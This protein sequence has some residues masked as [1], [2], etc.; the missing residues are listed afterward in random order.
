NGYHLV[1]VRSRGK[2]PVSPSWQHGEA[3][4]SLLRVTDDAANTGMLCSGL[5]VVD[6]D[7]DDPKLV[8]EIT[9]AVHDLLPRGAIIRRRAG[10]PRYAMVFRAE[11]EPGKLSV[12]SATGKVE[13]LGSGQQLVIDGVHPS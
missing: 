8:S 6:V 9:R 10:S 13:I 3:A 1:R 12:S 7:V 4:A 2:A 11:G 5:R